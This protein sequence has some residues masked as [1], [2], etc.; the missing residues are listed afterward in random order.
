MR[1]MKRILALALVAVLALSSTAL[2]CTGFYVGKDASADGTAIIGHTVDA[3]TTS[4][5][6][7][8][9]VPGVKDQPG[10]IYE[11][12]NGVKYPLPDTTYQYTTTPFTWGIWDGG[13]ANE[14]G[15][16]ISSAITCYV[17]DE[18][19]E[20]DPTLDTGLSEG[21]MCALVGMCAATAR[22]GV[23]VLADYIAEYGNAEQ[24][25][26][27]I[28]DP[29]EVWYME[30]YT[31]HQWCAVKAPDDCVSVFGN[32][33]MLGV[34]DLDSPDVLHS[35]GLVSMPEEHGLAVYDEKGNIDLFATYSG[36][37]LANASNRRTW[38]GHYMLAPSTAG[39]YGTKTR[40]DLFYQPDEKVTL[41]QVFEVT[42]AR[43]E[44][45]E[46]CPETTGRMDQRVIGTEKQANINAIQVYSDLPAP[47]A[48]VTWTC[49]AN[50][51]HSVYIPQSNLITDVAE[52]YKYVPEDGNNMDEHLAHYIYK[53]LCALAEQDRTYYG[54]GVRDYW[55]SVEAKEI[56]EFPQ[57]L[58]ETR[59]LYETNHAAAAKYITDYT[60]N[61]QNQNLADAKT[62]FNEL[63]WY[64]IANTN[65]QKYNYDGSTM[66]MGDTITQTPFVPSL[67]ETEDAQ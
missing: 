45:T 9:V 65:A 63:M 21:F 43:F 5:T 27:F 10:R 24:N 53:R 48:C 33:F 25:S 40:Y 35:E 38:Y 1:K 42:R 46:W 64:M 57:I 4:Q 60:I 34:V 18:I 44:G 67:L 37:A 13:T 11:I 50:A 16:A 7:S 15:V 26:F 28:A 19:A 31:G 2:A 39:E 66:T 12:F 14:M 22:E 17:S 8:E 55:K 56:A 36:N 41:D 29:N 51:E 3:S 61:L 23:Q 62:M 30:T 47:M 49:L 32:Q 52:D 6:Y 59:S 20:M 58:A 54:Q